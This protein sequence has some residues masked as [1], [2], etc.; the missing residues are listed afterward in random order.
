MQS[1]VDVAVET[2]YSAITILQDDDVTLSCTSSP[3]D[4]ALQWF[5]NGMYV[6]SSPQYQ[7]TQ[8]FYNGM[9]VSSSPQYWFFPPS[10]NHDLRIIHAD[11]TDSGR[12]TCAFVLGNEVIDQQSINLT[13]VPSEYYYTVNNVVNESFA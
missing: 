3:S 1:Y 12:Y 5:Y 8:W 6:S 10:L 9:D 11:V 2:A 4:I 7:F 13:V